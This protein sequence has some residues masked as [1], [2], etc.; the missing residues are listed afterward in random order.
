MHSFSKRNLIYLI[1]RRGYRAR[2]RL[3]F[4]FVRSGKRKTLT[5][6]LTEVRIYRQSFERSE[7]E[8]HMAHDQR[9]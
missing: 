1:T 8:F 4:G 2:V 3:A 9:V 7:L 5:H 6:R